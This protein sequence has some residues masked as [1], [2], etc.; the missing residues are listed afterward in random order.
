MSR[1]KEI[2]H[3]AIGAALYVALSATMKIPLIGHIQ[4][5]LGYVAFGAYL[6]MFGWQAAIVGVIGCLIESLVFSGWIPIG[7]M[8]G[9]TF[10]G[11]FCGAW[12]KFSNGRPNAYKILARIVATALGVFI[13]IGLIKTVIECGL[14]SISFEIKFAKNMIAFVADTVPM[15]LGVFIGERLK[16]EFSER[17]DRCSDL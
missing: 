6:V 1:A 2:C 10:I 12:Y 11:I 13:G 4:T 7:W 3:L 17:S 9:Q 14:Y 16:K 5:D 15:I 8:A